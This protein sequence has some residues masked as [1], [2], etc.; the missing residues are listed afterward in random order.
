MTGR[1]RGRKILMVGMA[2]WREAK[3]NGK[4]KEAE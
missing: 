1:K 2:V 4:E 3:K